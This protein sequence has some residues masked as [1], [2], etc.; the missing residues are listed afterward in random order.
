MLHNAAEHK[1]VD[2]FDITP[3]DITEFSKNRE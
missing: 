2:I 3:F 1:D